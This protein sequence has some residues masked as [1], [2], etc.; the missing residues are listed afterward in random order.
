MDKANAM[1]GR[2]WSMDGEVIHGDGRARKMNFPTAN[3][4][5]HEQIYPAKGVYAIKTQINK[6][7]YNKKVIIVVS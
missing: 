6:Q 1:L 4:S 2:P 3:I 7:N 5:P